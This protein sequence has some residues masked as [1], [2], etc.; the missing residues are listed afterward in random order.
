MELN[1]SPPPQVGQVWVIRWLASWNLIT[2]LDQMTLSGSLAAR[3]ISRDLIP[4]AVEPGLSEPLPHPLHQKCASFRPNVDFERASPFPL[5]C[6]T[7]AQGSMAKPHS[8][9]PVGSDEAMLRPQRC[10]LFKG[11][12]FLLRPL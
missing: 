9:M 6:G 8:F 4:L 12:L 1:L 10:L 5:N 2:E 11:Q 7:L 3:F